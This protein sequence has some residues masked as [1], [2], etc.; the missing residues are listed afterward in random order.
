M[1]PKLSQ[2]SGAKRVKK[3]EEILTHWK[4]IE[5]QYKLKKDAFEAGALEFDIT[6]T[7]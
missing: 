3:I 2:F 6:L 1:A 4:N 7:R 5:G